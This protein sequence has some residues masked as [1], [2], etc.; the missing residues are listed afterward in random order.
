MAHGM[1]MNS[2]KQEMAAGGWRTADDLTDEHGLRLILR[3]DGGTHQELLGRLPADLVQAEPELALLAAADR[4]LRDDPDVAG[5]DLR[6]AEQQAR[7][8]EDRHGRHALLLATCR[9]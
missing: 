5:I 2:I 3:S 6:L 9:T 8:P 7:L 4:L 1:V